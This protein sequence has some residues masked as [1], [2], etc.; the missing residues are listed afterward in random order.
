MTAA[1]AWLAGLALARI[2]FGMVP[3]ARLTRPGLP[4]AIVQGVVV[5]TIG[6][7]M[8]G[9]LSS[10]G[11]RRRLSVALRLAGGAT[12]GALVG[13]LAPT[14]V[15]LTRDELLAAASS[16]LGVAVAAFIAGLAAYS[17]RDAAVHETYG[18]GAADHITGIGS[19]E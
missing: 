7:L 2:W 19:P 1:A 8:V 11:R 13:T 5:A 16:T 18:A 15:Y 14:L 9:I 4:D 3:E 6:G 10:P 12:Y 17:W